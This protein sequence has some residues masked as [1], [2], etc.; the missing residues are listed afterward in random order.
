MLRNTGMSV[1][2]HGQDTKADEPRVPIE[3]D[4]P[5]PKKNPAKKLTPYTLYMRENYVTLKQQCRGDKKAI[6]T[7]CHDMWENESPEVKSMYERMAKEEDVDGG[8]N[9]SFVSLNSLESLETTLSPGT[10]VDYGDAAHQS[11]NMTNRS[12]NLESAVQFAGLV[13]AHHVDVSTR[14][15]EHLDVSHLLERAMLFRQ[16]I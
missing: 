9:E 2:V 12:L 8:T 14:D 11:K 5:V 6:F 3:N 13:A 1:P 15:L 4:I 7:K 16:E 10:S